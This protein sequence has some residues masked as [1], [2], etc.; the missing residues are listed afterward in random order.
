M[1]WLTLLENL[2]ASF[3]KAR[4]GDFPNS[5]YIIIV[6][7]GSFCGVYYLLLLDSQPL[8]VLA[9][10]FKLFLAEPAGFGSFRVVVRQV[11][12]LDDPVWET[13]ISQAF[14]SGVKILHFLRNSTNK[15]VEK[16]VIPLGG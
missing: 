7:V 12:F 15:S 10:L 14:L 9:Y 5:I 8:L 16:A 6:Y 4:K 13:E 3:W 11:L 1:P 2:W